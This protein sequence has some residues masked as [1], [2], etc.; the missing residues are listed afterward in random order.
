MFEL[1][2]IYRKLISDYLNYCTLIE[3]LW[4][5]NIVYNRNLCSFCLNGS[6]LND[7]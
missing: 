7:I 3:I 4:L 6:I 2:H 1:L 5:F